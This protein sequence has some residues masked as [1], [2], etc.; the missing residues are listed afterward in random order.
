MGNKQTVKSRFLL[1]LES[2]ALKIFGFPSSTHLIGYSIVLRWLKA[3]KKEKVCDIGCGRGGLCF[4]LFKKG[5]EICGVDISKDKMQRN[6][7]IFGR[8]IDFVAGNGESLPFCSCVFD[9]CVS[10]FVLEHFQNDIRA[11]KEI[12]RVL[13]PNGILVLTADSLSYPRANKNFVEK[14]NK[15]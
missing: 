12:N 4:K 14:E 1:F 5:C 10:T 7:K 9:K 2:I 13:K 15:A 11:L 3:Q 8:S 6:M